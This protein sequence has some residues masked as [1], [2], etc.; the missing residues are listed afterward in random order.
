MLDWHDSA[1]FMFMN[2]QEYVNIVKINIETSRFVLSGLS[3]VIAPFRYSL[4][5]MSAVWKI[6]LNKYITLL[7]KYIIGL[8]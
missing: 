6:T 1:Y 5:F 2:N 3:I 8:P 7:M 4:T